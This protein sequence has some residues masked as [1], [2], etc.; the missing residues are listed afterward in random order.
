MLSTAQFEQY[1]AAGRRGLDTAR[2]HTG[3]LA[4]AAGTAAA[5]TGVFTG[6]YTG[7]S[8]LATAVATGLGVLV[9]PTGRAEGHQAQTATILY[10]APGATLG[11]VLLV[12]RLLPA[13][14]GAHWGA[15]VAVAVWSAG[16]WLLR[17]ARAARRMLCPPAPAAPVEE[18]GLDLEAVLPDDPAARWWAQHAAVEGAAAPGTVLEDVERMGPSAMRAVIRSTTPGT[19]VPDISIRHL[20]ALMDVPEELIAI[21]PLPGRGASVRRLTV[22]QA[23]EI[24]PGAYWAKEIAPHAMPHSVITGIRRQSVTTVKELHP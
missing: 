3:R 19:P 6:D 4:T 17:P 20:S 24:D 8:L 21:G 15:A 22:G 14:T 12:E 1:L 16:T 9:L 7:P 11:V 2:S 18:A 23:V 5:G 13:T 10:V